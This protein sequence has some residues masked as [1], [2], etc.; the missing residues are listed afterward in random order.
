[1]NTTTQPL[2]ITINGNDIEDTNS[3]N[4]TYQNYVI[5]M[6]QRLQKENIDLVKEI[7]E[8]NNRNDDLEEQLDKEEKSKTYM[9]GLLQNVYDMK[10]K[11]LEISALRKR[12]FDQHNLHTKNLIKKPL[13]IYVV[14]NTN[15]CL[16]IREYYILSFIIMPMFAFMTS[17]INVRFFCVLFFLS[18]Y[19][20]TVL[21]YYIKSE[22]QKNSSEYEQLLN[23]YS[24]INND[25][26]K[27]KKEIDEI[28]LSCNCL[29]NY[30]DEI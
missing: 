26:K 5:Q 27:L 13:K 17:I 11:A 29:N 14:P 9:K 23:G 7:A 28:E 19:P 1:M 16:N 22:V 2:N 30:I 15:L 25:A 4:D 18:V 24:A 6:N 3:S 21:Y 20:G 8:L 10:N 12:L